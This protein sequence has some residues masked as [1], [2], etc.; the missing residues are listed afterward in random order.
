MHSRLVHITSKLKLA[1]V[2]QKW[3]QALPANR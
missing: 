3:E 2:D 1:T